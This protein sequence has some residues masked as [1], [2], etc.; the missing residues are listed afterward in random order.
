MIYF[1]EKSYLLR[2]NS[3]KFVAPGKHIV[4][5][6]SYSRVRYTKGVFIIRMLITYYT[7]IYNRQ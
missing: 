7:N 3:M 2:S 4:C 5:N 1:N 6:T